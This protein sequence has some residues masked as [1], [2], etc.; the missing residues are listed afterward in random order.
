MMD[1]N[2]IEPN[3]IKTQMLQTQVWAQVLEMLR[4]RPIADIV[5]ET[6]RALKDL[7]V[8]RP[9]LRSV[10]DYILCDVVQSLYL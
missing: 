7:K 8:G 10:V 6:G 1:G 5:E 9:V 4:W 2:Q 3:R